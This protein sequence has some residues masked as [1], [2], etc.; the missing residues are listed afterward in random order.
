LDKAM[1]F[2]VVTDHTPRVLE[3]RAVI[4]RFLKAQEQPELF[5]TAA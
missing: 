2:I 1:P 3:Q 5:Q 4:S